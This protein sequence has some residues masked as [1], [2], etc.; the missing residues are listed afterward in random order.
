MNIP[1][2]SKCHLVILW[3]DV[4]SRHPS[5]HLLEGT[6]YSPEQLGEDIG[7]PLETLGSFN[8]Q[9]ASVLA[10][11]R[12]K[13]KFTTEHLEATRSFDTHHNFSFYT[14]LSTQL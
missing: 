13:L 4:L 11:P 1:C 14:A 12:K 9:R 5:G 6:D 8:M 7:E 10:V 2:G 3:V